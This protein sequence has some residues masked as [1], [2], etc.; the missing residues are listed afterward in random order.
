MPKILVKMNDTQFGTL[1]A[2]LDSWETYPKYR[3]L[4]EVLETPEWQRKINIENT[5]LKVS[6]AITYDIWNEFCQHLKMK[7][8]FPS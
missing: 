2:M 3:G 4:I 5:V 8:P 1:M 6:G 7:I